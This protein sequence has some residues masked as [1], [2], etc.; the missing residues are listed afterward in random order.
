MGA[1]ILLASEDS[2]SEIVISERGLRHERLLVALPSCPTIALHRISKYNEKSLELEDH[3]QNDL[4]N[5]F[6]KL[7]VCIVFFLCCPLY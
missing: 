6:V 1:M 7:T 2:H 5:T 3:I 4:L